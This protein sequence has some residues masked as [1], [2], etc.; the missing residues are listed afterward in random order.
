MMMNSFK[1]SFTKSSDSSMVANYRPK[2]QENKDK[3]NQKNRD[4]D[5]DKYKEKDEYIDKDKYIDKEKDK[6]REKEKKSRW[7]T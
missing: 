3:I 6:Y 1:M 7:D 4:N 5:K 2:T